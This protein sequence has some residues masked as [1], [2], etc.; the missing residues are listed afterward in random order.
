[1]KTG[2]RRSAEGDAGD[3]DMDMGSGMGLVTDMGRVDR[4][5]EG[6][7]AIPYDGNIFG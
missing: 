6:M 5:F 7:G 1:M 3:M 2:I 4:R